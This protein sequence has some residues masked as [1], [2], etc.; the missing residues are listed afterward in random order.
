MWTREWI[1]RRDMLGASVCFL[2]EVA[3]EDPETYKNHLRVSKLQFEELLADIEP[4][5]KKQDTMMRNALSPRVKLEI[6]LRFLATGNSFSSLEHMYR[7]PKTISKFLK[8][9]LVAIYENRKHYIHVSNKHYV[10]NINLLIIT[11]RHSISH[12]VRRTSWCRLHSTS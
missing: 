4:L 1:K 12:T 10:L 2:T 9:V 3:T 6:T 8:Y 5:I 7:V 11:T